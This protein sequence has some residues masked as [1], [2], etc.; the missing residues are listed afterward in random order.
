MFAKFA[1]FK[2]MFEKFANF[3]K[4]AKK[5]RENEWKFLF[6]FTYSLPEPN[7]RERD[8][9]KIWKTSLSLSCNSAA[10]KHAFLRSIAHW[11]SRASK[12]KNNPTEINERRPSETLLIFSQTHY[13]ANLPNL[14]WSSILTHG[15]QSIWEGG[16]GPKQPG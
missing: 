14:S 12:E 8:W 5:F 10:I 13:I 9:T 3:A 11:E 4:M 15:C 1:N 6:S 7:F 2:K 16:G